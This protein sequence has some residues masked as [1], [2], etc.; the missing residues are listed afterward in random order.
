MWNYG[1]KGETMNIASE[2]IEIVEGG[3]Q[4]NQD[5]VFKYTELLITKLDHEQDA[6]L[7]KALKRRL[8]GSYLNDLPISARTNNKKIVSVE[9]QWK[10]LYKRFN[11]AFPDCAEYDPYHRQLTWTYFED[12]ADDVELDEWETTEQQIAWMYKMFLEAP[13]H[14]DM[15]FKEEDIKELVIRGKKYLFYLSNRGDRKTHAFVFDEEHN[16][17]FKF[18]DEHYNPCVEKMM[19]NFKK[20]RDARVKQ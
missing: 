17:L 20:I 8:D 16:L 2:I 15:A 13:K 11:K 12:D 14:R 6:T 19:N 7:I 18:A 4:G 1:D 5:K 3:L 10:V 9:L